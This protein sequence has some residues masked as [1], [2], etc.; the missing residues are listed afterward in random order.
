M[1][2]EKQKLA[3][4]R[5]FS[6]RPTQV[7]VTCS[8]QNRSRRATLSDHTDLDVCMCSKSCIIHADK[9]NY[10]MYSNLIAEFKYF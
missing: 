1:C 8:S 9:T 6:I 4:G 10:S 5:A 2:E 7:L 3:E